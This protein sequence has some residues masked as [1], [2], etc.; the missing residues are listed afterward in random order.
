MLASLNAIGGPDAGRLDAFNTNF[1][2]RAY[3]M[4]PVSFLVLTCPQSGREEEWASWH[5]HHV[6]DVLKVPGF[7][8][9]R[10]FRTLDL[11]SVNAKPAWRYGVLYE[12]LTDD[13]QASLAELRRRAGTAQMPMS[14]A[15]DPSKTVSIMLEQLSTHER[16]A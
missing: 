6:E 13:P 14:P 10:R 3:V 5:E 2:R 8:S 4:Q 15:S 16:Q 7:I 9:C 11:G 12:L 1:M